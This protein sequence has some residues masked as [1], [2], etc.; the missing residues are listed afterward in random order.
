MA[1]I[2]AVRTPELLRVIVSGRL[3]SGDMGRLEHACSPA[4]VNDSPRLEVDLA[5][6]TLLDRTASAV[7]EQIAQRGVRI[8][9][10]RHPVI[11]FLHG[12]DGARQ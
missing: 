10:P 8:I 4:L 12:G 7:V 5:A 1:R 9:Q 2:R 11:A 3:L 6:V